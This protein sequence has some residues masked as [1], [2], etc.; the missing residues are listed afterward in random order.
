MKLHLA[1]WLKQG[2]IPFW[3]QQIYCGQPF[4]ALPQAALYYPLT[5]IFHLFD[6]VTGLNL[7]VFIHYVIALIS[8][9][10][11][12]RIFRVSP[13]ASLFSAITFGFSGAMLS[14]HSLVDYQQAI[15]WLPLILIFYHLYW[16]L[17]VWGSFL[18]LLVLRWLFVEMF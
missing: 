11:M 6:G 14:L 17:D 12:M 8:F 18:L 9:Y 2:I 7:F 5:V 10:W 4:A 16:W 15:V 3:N 13:I 1:H